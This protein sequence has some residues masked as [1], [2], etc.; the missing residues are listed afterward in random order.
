MQ[1]IAES[2][3]AEAKRILLL[4]C[5]D[6]H[7]ELERREK[8]EYNRLLL[9]PQYREARQMPPHSLRRHVMRDSKRAGE[10]PSWI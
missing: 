6:S 2:R 5:L 10:S 1:A 8:R 9:E 4:H 7:L 3:V